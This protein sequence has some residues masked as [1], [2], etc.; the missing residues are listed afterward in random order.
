MLFFQLKVRIVNKIL[1]VKEQVLGINR[2]AQ[3]WLVN[4]GLLADGRYVGWQKIQEN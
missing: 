3:N 1:E 4:G 2:P